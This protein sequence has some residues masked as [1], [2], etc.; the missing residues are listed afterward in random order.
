MSNTNFGQK[1]RSE[2]TGGYLTAK[3]LDFGFFLK[4]WNHNYKCTTINS[5]ESKIQNALSC[6]L[7]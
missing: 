6:Q 7:V 2:I 1:N 3:F 5:I 4:I